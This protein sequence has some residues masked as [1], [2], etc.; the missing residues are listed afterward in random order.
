MQALV[1]ITQRELSEQLA[2]ELRQID[3]EPIPAADMASALKEYELRSPAL[4][5][6][7]WGL[8]ALDGMTL[9]RE[10]R[11]NQSLHN[12]LVLMISDRSATIDLQAMLDGGAD[13][14][15]LHPIESDRFR[16][17]LRIAR[18]CA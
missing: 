9:C 3:V 14:Y 17:R 4:L 5:I 6:T 11:K 10:V 12:P 15:I 18:A 1:A 2:S 16:I 13:D 8:D 7:S